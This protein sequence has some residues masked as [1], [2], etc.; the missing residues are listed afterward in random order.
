MS[1]PICFSEIV[2]PVFL[3]K[4]RHS[5]CFD[6]VLRWTAVELLER[7]RTVWEYPRCFMCRQT[8][9]VILTL[10]CDEVQRFKSFNGVTI[11][12]GIS[13]HEYAQNGFFHI[14]LLGTVLE[15]T[16]SNAVVCF[17]C[18]FLHFLQDSID[19]NSLKTTHL[20]KFPNCPTARVNITGLDLI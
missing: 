1:C 19:V 20:A 10:Y 5:G 18:G 8:Y 15:W 13:P 14:K 12:D 4:C 11:R 6:C 16:T 17:D 7:G 2:N 3:S 9:D